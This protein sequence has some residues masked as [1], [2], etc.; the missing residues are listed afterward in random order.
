MDGILIVLWSS[1]FDCI[2]FGLLNVAARNELR[3]MCL[4]SFLINLIVDLSFVN[5][6]D[7]CNSA[8]IFLPYP[9]NTQ[10]LWTRISVQR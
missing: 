4:L 1:W 7:L 6:Q 8:L 5:T 10:D 9:F 3:Y 2:D